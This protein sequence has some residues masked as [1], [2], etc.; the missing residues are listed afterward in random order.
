MTDKQ[1][2]TVEDVE[3]VTVQDEKEQIKAESSEKIAKNNRTPEPVVVKKGGAGLG[4]LALLVA[5]GVGG[6]GYYFGQQQVEQIQQKL[7]ALESQKSVAVAELPNLDQ[8]KSEMTNLIRQGY[9]NN[10]DKIT[11]LQQAL[12]EKKP[13]PFGSTNSN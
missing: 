3:S 8:A 12:T 9:Q 1:T 11:A 13:S 10:A 6:A 7:N 5:L 4:F 2:E